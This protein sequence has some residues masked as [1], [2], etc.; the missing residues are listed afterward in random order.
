LRTN[1]D[2]AIPPPRD[3]QPI[4]ARAPRVVVVDDQ[5]RFRDAA[6]ALLER[7]GY[8]VVGE[9]GC[10]ATAL[11][12][13]ERLGPAAVLL[14]VRL[15]DDDGLEV[16]AAL[17]RAYPDV[18]VVLASDA[19]YGQLPDLVRASGAAG[20]VRKSQLVQTDFE[21]FWPRG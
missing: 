8:A 13:V 17:T 10:R 21:R 6:R 11:E 14:D 7:R 19:D 2:T 16:C 4:D 1:T 3:D 12:A 9:A 5:R 20:F 18:T 15:G